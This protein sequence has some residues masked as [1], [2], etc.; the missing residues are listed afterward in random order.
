MF[1]FLLQSVNELKL[2]II[3]E[4][5]KIIGKGNKQARKHSQLNM[6]W[7]SWNIKC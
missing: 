7:V 5:I 3:K 2:A 1:L 4:I 6:S